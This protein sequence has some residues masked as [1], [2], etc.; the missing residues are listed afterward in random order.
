M[1][2]AKAVDFLG[3][4]SGIVAATAAPTTATQGY[5][6]KGHRFVNLWVSCSAGTSVDV[7]VYIYRIGIGWLLYTDVPTTTMLTANGGG[8]LQLELRGAQRVYLRHNSFNGGVTSG[9]VAE[10]IT[11]GA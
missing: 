11:Y 8:I 10:G 3:S 9:I 2:I 4:T 7:S 5:E 6:T 1:S